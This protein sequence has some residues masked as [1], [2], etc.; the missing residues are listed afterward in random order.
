MSLRIK[1]FEIKKFLILL[2][3]FTSFFLGVLALN[4]NMNMNDNGKMSRCNLIGME[5]RPCQMTIND[6]LGR[7]QQMFATIVNWSPTIVLLLMVAI[8]IGFVTLFKN[9]EH[10]FLQ[11][12]QR[13]KKENSIFKLFDYLLLAFSKGILH[14][15][16]Y[17]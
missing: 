14:P 17:A 7:W 11:L 4:L 13:Y 15:Q 16:I 2:T 1:L 12:H 8:T 5:S 3:I 6:H 9:L 10:V